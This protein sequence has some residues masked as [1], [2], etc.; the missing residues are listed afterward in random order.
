MDTSPKSE[1]EEGGS[2]SPQM[3]LRRLATRGSLAAVD[4]RQGAEAREIG[5]FLTA[6]AC[7]EHK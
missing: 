3:A 5:A 6:N 1:I 4:G 2:E 7:S